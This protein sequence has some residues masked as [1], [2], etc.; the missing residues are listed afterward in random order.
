VGIEM[1]FAI[2]VYVPGKRCSSI[3]QRVL[4]ALQQEKAS[5]SFSLSPSSPSTPILP[6]STGASALH[7]DPVGCVRCL[8]A[9]RTRRSSM[10]V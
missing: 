1:P 10:S 8:F 6:L 4:S 5:P 9:P 7:N 3:W 2:A